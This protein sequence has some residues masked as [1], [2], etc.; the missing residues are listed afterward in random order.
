MVDINNIFM[1]L[2]ELSHRKSKISLQLPIHTTTQEIILF[3]WGRVNSYE[4]A[5]S[6]SLSNLSIS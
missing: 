3:T 4:F 6:L 5:K 1:V 2:T